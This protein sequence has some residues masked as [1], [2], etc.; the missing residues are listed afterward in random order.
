MSF[1]NVNRHHAQH[2]IAQARDLGEEVQTVRA[3]VEAGVAR[4]L[5]TFGGSRRGGL[6]DLQGAAG[7]PWGGVDPQRMQSVGK[8]Y[9]AAARAAHAAKT[10]N[11]SELLAAA[12]ALARELG[13]AKRGGDLYGLGKNAN[14]LIA[15]ISSGN[16]GKIA[17]ASLGIFNDLKK[18]VRDFSGPAAPPRDGDPNF[19]GPPSDLAGPMD[20]DPNFMGPPSDLA[21]PV[22][23]DPNF[24]G[25]PSSLAGP[26]DGDP[27]LMGP[28]SDLAGPMD[29]D[30]NFMGP[31][32][33]LA[34]PMDGDPSFV[35]SPSDFGGS[36]VN[37]PGFAIQPSDVGATPVDDP[38]FSVQ[39][40]DFTDSGSTSGAD[41]T[42]SDGGS[43]FDFSTDGGD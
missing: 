41:S 7:S 3:E 13:G 18:T 32:S 34:G 31:P 24:M 1:H 12:G 11:R 35:G 23:G 22:D 4:A 30:P 9:S 29:G 25:P 33:A 10:G 39:P 28:P 27:N 26:M 36:T 16:V 15:A 19:M 42:G 17:Q 40:S 20:G 14:D 6:V 5:D 2:R 43:S 38:G 8:T 37:D 21:G